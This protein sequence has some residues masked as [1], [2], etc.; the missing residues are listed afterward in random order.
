[1]NFKNGLY[2]DRN[3]AYNERFRKMAAL[4]RVEN[5]FIFSRRLLA[6]KKPRCRHL[7]KPLGRYMPADKMSRTTKCKFES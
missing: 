7:A 4:S 1:M 2:E 5:I 3:T 6:L